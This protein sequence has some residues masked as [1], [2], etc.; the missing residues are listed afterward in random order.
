[1][2]EPF[3]DEDVSAQIRYAEAHAPMPLRKYAAAPQPCSLSSAH[4]LTGP[5]H[6]L[7]LT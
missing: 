6:T 7:T 1:M 3:H 2:Y 5:L 4:T